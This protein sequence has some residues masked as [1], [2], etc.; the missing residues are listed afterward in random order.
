[1]ITRANREGAAGAGLMLEAP[2]EKCPRYSASPT[3]FHQSQSGVAPSQIILAE[4]L[5]H[6][7]VHAQLESK[8]R[9]SR[10]RSRQKRGPPSLF[11]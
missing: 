5:S 9:I 6:P 2:L 1:M 4:L 8:Q 3:V 11:L 7:A 10:S